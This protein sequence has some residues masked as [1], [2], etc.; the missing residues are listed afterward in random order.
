MRASAFLRLSPRLVL[1]PLRGANASSR[2]T[3]R[4]IFREWLGCRASIRTKRLLG[5]CNN[6]SVMAQISKEKQNRFWAR[7]AP[8]H[9]PRRSHHGQPPHSSQAD[10]LTPAGRRRRD[11]DDEVLRLAHQ[12]ATCRNCA[13]LLTCRLAAAL[14][15]SPLARALVNWDDVPRRSSGDILRGCRFLG[16]LLDSGREMSCSAS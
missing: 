1:V 12:H 15:V 14:M 5:R 7:P 4:T 2:Y 6:H 16:S 11:F 9:G 3:L 13:V 8:T 10:P